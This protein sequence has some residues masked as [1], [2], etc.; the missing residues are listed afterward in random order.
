MQRGRLAD[1][2]LPVGARW[3]KRRLWRGALRRPELIGLIRVTPADISRSAHRG[4]AS[5]AVWAGKKQLRCE[6]CGASSSTLAS[7]PRASV[8]T[9]RPEGLAGRQGARGDHAES[10]AVG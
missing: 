7:A 9:L 6:R 2:A 3:R 8:R 10:S 1:A 5:V 4:A